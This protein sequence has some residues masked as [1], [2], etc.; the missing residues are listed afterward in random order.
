MVDP[1]EPPHTPKITPK[2]AIHLAEALARG[3]PHG[4]KIART[5]AADAVRELV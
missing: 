1:N 4:E 5:I 2:Q 3:T